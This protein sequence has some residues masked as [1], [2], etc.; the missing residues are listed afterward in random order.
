MKKALFSLLLCCVLLL[1]CSAKLPPSIEVITPAPAEFVTIPTAKPIATIPPIT[2]PPTAE[3]VA[4]DT[5]VPTAEPVPT[6]SIEAYIATMTTEQKLGQL[7][8]FGFSGTKSVSDTFI[9]IMAQYKLGNVILYG[10]NISRT[11]SDGGFSQCRRLTDDIVEHNSSNLP[12]LISTDVEGGNVTRFKWPKWPTHA[13]TLGDR[14]DHQQAYDQFVMIAE[15]LLSVGINVDLAPCLDVAKHP[16]DT[17]LEK[18]IISANADIVSTI[19]LRCIEGLQN[20]GMMSIVKHFPGHGAT[21]ADSHEVTPVV[22]KTLEDLMEYE[23]VPFRAAVDGGVDGIMVG[24]IFYPNIDEQ[25]IA[26]MS[27]VIITDVLRGELGFDGV[28][29]SDDFRMAGLRKRYKLEDA[30]VQFILSGGDLI[31]CG[32]NHDYQRQILKG[33]YSAVEDGTLSEQR[34]NESV[35][36]ILKVKERVTGF[37]F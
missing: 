19:G 6:D 15:G 29:M 17:F 9:D 11:N 24:H 20:S 18:R 1:G 32:A 37:A 33:L 23:L 36:R 22:N 12:L 16:M 13:K 35:Y 30:A 34:I 5:P 14:E 27:K 10:Q 3:P 7:C 2:P 28:V 21:T 26:S 8:M 4:T 31:L 25:D